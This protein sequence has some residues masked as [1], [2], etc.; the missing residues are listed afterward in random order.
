VCPGQQGQRIEGLKDTSPSE[1]QS[2]GEELNRAVTIEELNAALAEMK[3]DAASTGCNISDMIILTQGTSPEA[4]AIRTSILEHIQQTWHQADPTADLSTSKVTPIVKGVGEP[5]DA[6]NYR[7]IAVSSAISKVVQIVI[8]K[9]LYDY[10]INV[11]RAVSPMQA[12]F[13]KGRG[14]LE[15]LLFNDLI[16][17]ACTAAQN[18]PSSWM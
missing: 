9:R 18:H 7:T 17:A 14:T 13:L 1:N 2:K 3:R 15:Q 8:H 5:K 10:I 11:I 12:G 16:T 4:E 6:E